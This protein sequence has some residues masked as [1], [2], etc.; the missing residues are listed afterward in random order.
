[1]PGSRYRMPATVPWR[2]SDASARPAPELVQTGNYSLRVLRCSSTLHLQSRTTP[3][4]SR[5]QV[6]WWTCSLLCTDEFPYS[7]EMMI[8]V[9]GDK[10]QMVHQP[11]RRL[12]TRVRN[13]SGK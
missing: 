5:L 6:E 13:G 12:Q 4:S 7:R 2:P 8:V 11:H 10:V 9:F 1:M 3:P